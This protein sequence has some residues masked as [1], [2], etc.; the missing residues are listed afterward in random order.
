MN[1]VG[2]SVSI[3]KQELDQGSQMEVF[4]HPC[5]T[6][7]FILPD[8][9]KPASPA[10]LIRP[11]TKGKL[12]NHVIV[13]IEHYVSLE[14]KE[15]CE[16]MAFLVAGTTPKYRESNPVYAFRKIEGEDGAFNVGDRFGTFALKSFNLIQVVRRI[17]ISDAERTKGI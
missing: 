14:S 16:D 11:I 6:G 15:D 4:V 3:P 13:H 12:Q 10:Y 1:F 2:V 17:N 7:S 8:G 5:V 9:Y